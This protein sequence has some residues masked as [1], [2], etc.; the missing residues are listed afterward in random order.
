MNK[1]EYKKYLRSEHW[2]SLKY[3]HRN[4]KCAVCGS[5]KTDLHHKK[6]SNLNNEKYGSDLV[7]LCRHHHNEV[8]KFHS[9]SELSLEKATNKYIS[10]NKSFKKKKKSVKE[11]KSKEK[12]K[13]DI[14][15]ELE[16]DKLLNELNKTKELGRVLKLKSKEKIRYIDSY[17]EPQQLRRKKR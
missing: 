16:C 12:S 9:E 10:Q 1:A 3:I 13:K 7:A 2:L 5:A 17:E 6:Y 11:K 15:R 4:K 8:H 14:I